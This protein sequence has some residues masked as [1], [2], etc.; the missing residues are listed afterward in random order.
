MNKTAP[1]KK[2]IAKRS[3]MRVNISSSVILGVIAELKVN[4]SMAVR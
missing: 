3:V 4:G 2:A 1:S